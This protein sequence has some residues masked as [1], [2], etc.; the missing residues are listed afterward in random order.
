MIKITEDTWA[1]ID[2]MTGWPVR[3][4]D[5]RE[6]NRGEMYVVAGGRAPLHSGS[7]GRIYVALEGVEPT[8]QFYPSVFG[9]RWID[10]A[11]ES[12][13][14]QLTSQYTMD[15]VQTMIEAGGGFAAALAQAFLKADL[16][17]RRKLMGTFEELFLKHAEMAQQFAAMEGLK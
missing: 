15:G 3:V 14:L 16:S 11:K 7:T 10:R 13:Q 12:D 6:S 2:D 8:T 17:N 5:V 1:L 9:A 4:G